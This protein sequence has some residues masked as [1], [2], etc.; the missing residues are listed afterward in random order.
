MHKTLVAMTLA[1]SL[2]GCGPSA[3]APEKPKPEVP[4]APIDISG[5]WSSGCVAMPGPDGSASYVRLDFDISAE[6]WAL[7]FQRFGDEACSQKLLTVHLDGPYEV[8]TPSTTV[9]GAYNG[10]FRFS[11]KAVTPHAQPLVDMLNGAQCGPGNWKID[12]AQ[13]VYDAGCPALGLYPRS[14]CTADY[15]LVLVDGNK[16][17]F[18]VRPEDN[19]MC[20]EERR[21]T[22]LNPMA[23]T[24]K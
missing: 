4:K 6:L 9:T 10:Q 18:G 14:E 15:D 5:A 8:S 20:S 17:Q 12:Q 24:R 19:N 21:P 2:A 1:A 3:P 13:D 22:S 11:T 23:M 16:L 7:D